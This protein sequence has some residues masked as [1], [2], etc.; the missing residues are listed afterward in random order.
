MPSISTFAM[1]AYLTRRSAV[2]VA[3]APAVLW[4]IVLVA[5]LFI[6]PQDYRLTVYILL[7]LN[8]AGSAGDFV[9]VY[10]VSRQQPDALI[11]DDGNK[12]LVFVPQDP[13]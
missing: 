2:I 5:A 1:S 10:V 11:Q 13:R 9:E 4:G 12:V 8:F 3:L 7:A 6:V